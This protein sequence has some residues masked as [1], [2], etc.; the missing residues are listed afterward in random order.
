[1]GRESRVFLP[2]GKPYAGGGGGVRCGTVP[3]HVV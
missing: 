1:V 2:N 3:L